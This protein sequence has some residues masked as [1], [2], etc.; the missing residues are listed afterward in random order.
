MVAFAILATMLGNLALRLDVAAASG[1]AGLFFT[2]EF[3]VEEASYEAA[4]AYNTSQGLLSP[5]FSGWAAFNPGSDIDLSTTTD[6]EDCA[7]PAADLVEFTDQD[8]ALLGDSLYAAE[9][10]CVLGA[11]G[12]GAVAGLG[13]SLLSSGLLRRK[14]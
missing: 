8:R 11:A 9:S 4:V 14:A 13:A 3:I 2:T 10:R 5:S 12:A 1:L 7:G 6:F